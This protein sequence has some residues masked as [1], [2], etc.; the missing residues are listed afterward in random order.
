[1]SITSSDECEA[2]WGYKFT[3]PPCPINAYKLITKGKLCCVPQLDCP[4]GHIPETPQ[5]PDKY[6]NGSL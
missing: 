6:Y 5:D 4:P 1:M 2:G 3:E